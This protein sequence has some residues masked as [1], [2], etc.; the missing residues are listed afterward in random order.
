MANQWAGANKWMGGFI[1]T[2]TCPRCG[3]HGYVTHAEMGDDIQA[4]KRKRES[5]VSELRSL[6]ELITSIEL[7]T[8]YTNRTYFISD[9]EAVK[10]GYSTDPESRLRYLQ[11]GHPKKLVLLGVCSI[12]EPVLHEKFESLRLQGE[13]FRLTPELEGY[14]RD[15]VSASEWRVRPF[16]V[17]G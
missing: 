12:P 13:W 1:P 8:K 6:T 9:G 10:I 15:V 7:D 17:A 4:L 11:T 16:H 5:L 2:C 14:I 3:G